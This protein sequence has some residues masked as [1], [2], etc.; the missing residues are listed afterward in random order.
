[1]A[2]WD[3]EKFSFRKVEVDSIPCKDCKYAKMN[4]KFAPTKGE[5]EKYKLKPMDVLLDGADCPDYKQK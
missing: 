4:G 2:R 5:C 3:N 1:M